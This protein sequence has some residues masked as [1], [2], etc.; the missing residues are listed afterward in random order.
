MLSDR[1]EHADAWKL[2][3]VIC[4]VEVADADDE[5]AGKNDI[6][7][8]CCSNVD[9]DVVEVLLLQAATATP[10]HR[11]VEIVAKRHIDE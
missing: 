10:F 3:V 7:I 2:R 1:L 6:P 5:E 4:E 8:C 11:L 9:V